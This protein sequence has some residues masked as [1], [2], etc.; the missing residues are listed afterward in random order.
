M[1]EWDFSVVPQNLDLLLLG[2]VNTLRIAVAAF[3]LGLPLGLGLALMRLSRARVV[4]APTGFVI[5]FLRSAPAL[6]QLFWFFFAFPLL[7]GARIDAFEAGALSL[8]FIAAAFY[9]EVFRGGISSIERGQWESGRALGMTYA[10]LMRRIILPQA[11]KRM[12]PAFLERTIELVKTTTLAATIAYGD[13]LFQAMDIAQKTF[14]S[15]EIFT[16]VAAIYF[17][18]LYPSSL[19]VRH[20]ERRLAVS[21]ESTVH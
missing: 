14:R 13:L 11:V 20:L 18:I 12:I 10:A 4:S 19:A 6:V 21:G 7:I 16:A 15:L 5:D 1:Y 9:A 8:A 2:L 17:I 3:V